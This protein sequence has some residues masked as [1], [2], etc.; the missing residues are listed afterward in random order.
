MLIFNRHKEKKSSVSDAGVIV[1]ETSS[2]SE[3]KVR[4]LLSISYLL[5]YFSVKDQ[6]FFCLGTLLM[7]EESS[8][9]C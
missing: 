5:A 6:H 9:H 4:F 8:G 1:R 2:S 3:F 7:Y